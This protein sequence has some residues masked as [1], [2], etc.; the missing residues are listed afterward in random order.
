LALATAH[1]QLILERMKRRSFLTATLLAS[2]IFTAVAAPAPT[3]KD[4]GVDKHR[5][6]KMAGPLFLSTCSIR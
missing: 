4:E 3:R 5:H 6:F 2:F 1:F